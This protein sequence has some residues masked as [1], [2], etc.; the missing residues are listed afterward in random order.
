MKTT[1]F[2]G[3]I[4]ELISSLFWIRIINRNFYLARWLLEV[5][6]GNVDI[7]NHDERLKKSAET[8]GVG[9]ISVPRHFHKMGPTQWEYNDLLAKEGGFEPIP[10]SIN[11]LYTKGVDHKKTS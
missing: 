2:P 6:S 1:G 3:I 5:W 8:P 4:L 9:D 11:H 7:P 10:R